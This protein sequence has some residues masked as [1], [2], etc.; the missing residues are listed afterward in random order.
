MLGIDYLVA[1]EDTRFACGYPRESN[2]N[3]DKAC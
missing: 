3:G 2:F 1:F